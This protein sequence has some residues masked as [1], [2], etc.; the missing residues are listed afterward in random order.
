ME[1]VNDRFNSDDLIAKGGPAF[2]TKYGAE[3]D[4]SGLGMS[5][6]DYF[7]AQCMSTMVHRL[8][9]DL[10]AGREDVDAV[11]AGMANGCYRLADAMLEARKR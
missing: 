3:P 6:R 9:M 2:P 1:A 8:P 10:I 7:A 4:T 11:I 5:L